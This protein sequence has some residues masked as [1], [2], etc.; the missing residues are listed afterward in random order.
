[1]KFESETVYYILVEAGKT[2]INFSILEAD[3]VNISFKP[4]GDFYV[5]NYNLALWKATEVIKKMHNTKVFGDGYPN[6]AL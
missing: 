5:G 3:V 4:V 6:I 2:K 1:M